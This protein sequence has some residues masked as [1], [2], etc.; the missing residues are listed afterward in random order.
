M[1]RALRLHSSDLSR[2]IGNALAKA[3]ERGFRVKGLEF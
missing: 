2:R 1:R 3:A